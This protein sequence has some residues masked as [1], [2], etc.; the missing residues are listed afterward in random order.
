MS[1]NGTPITRELTIELWVC[2][3]CD[4]YY[5]SSSIAGKDLTKIVNEQADLQHNRD[6]RSFDPDRPMGSRRSQCPS[7]C[8]DDDGAPAQRRMVLAKVDTTPRT[9]VQPSA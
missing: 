2:D 7:G 8:R 5:A 6:F 9:V 4:A 1:L 3:V